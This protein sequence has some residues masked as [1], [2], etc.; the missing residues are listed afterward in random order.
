M[1][2]TFTFDKRTR[3][4]LVEYLQRPER[5]VSLTRI[6]SRVVGN[7]HW[8]VVERPDGTRSIGLDLLSGGGRTGHG[9][10]WK[11]LSECEGPNVSDCPLSLLALAGDWAP[12]GY[13]AEWRERVRAY[14]A[15]KNQHAKCL[16]AGALVKYGPHVYRLD[17]P[18]GPRR[19]WNVTRL[20]GV[21]FRMRANQLAQAAI[22]TGEVT[23]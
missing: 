4:E 10:G 13:A 11:D 17:T 7:H 19:G 12:D 3:A 8:Y 1:G 16:V 5:Y 18:A 23:A 2:W 14:H 22:I 21:E 20:D 9:W 15:K 6:A